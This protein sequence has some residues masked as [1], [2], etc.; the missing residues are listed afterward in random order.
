MFGFP[1]PIVQIIWNAPLHFAEI[2]PKV[3]H[4]LVDY[5]C[6]V[7]RLPRSEELEVTVDSRCNIEG[8][9]T[10]VIQGSRTRGYPLWIL[11]SDFSKL[12]QL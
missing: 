11:I 7:G 8:Q 3:S 9:I 2:A 1:V 5:C 12:C 6:D 4:Q 10:V